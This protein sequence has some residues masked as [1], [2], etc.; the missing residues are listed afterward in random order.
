MGELKDELQ[1]MDIGFIEDKIPYCGMESP[2]YRVFVFGCDIQR[3][4]H[5]KEKYGTEK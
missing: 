5:L 1:K 3:T 4:T 2:V